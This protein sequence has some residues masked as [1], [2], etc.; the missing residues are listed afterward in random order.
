MTTMTPCFILRTVKVWPAGEGGRQPRALV[1]L[2]RLGLVGAHAAGRLPAEDGRGAC[3]Y[4]VATCSCSGWVAG[5]HGQ[6]S[7]WRR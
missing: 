1:R 2:C 3:A 7:I 6:V 4:A 5:S